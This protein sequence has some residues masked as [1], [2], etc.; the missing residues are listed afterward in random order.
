[1]PHLFLNDVCICLAFNKCLPWPFPALYFYG[2][3]RPSSSSIQQV[4]FIVWPHVHYET[5]D[6]VFS[7]RFMLV[8][9]YSRFSSADAFLQSP[10]STFFSR[11]V[12]NKVQNRLGRIYLQTSE[13]ITV[14][15]SKISLHVQSNLLSSPEWNVMSLHPDRGERTRT[16]LTRGWHSWSSVRSF[17]M[18]SRYFV[19]RIGIITLFGGDRDTFVYCLYQGAQVFTHFKTWRHSHS[20]VWIPMAMKDVFSFYSVWWVVLLIVVRDEWFSFDCLDLYVLLAIKDWDS[21]KM[22][23]FFNYCPETRFLLWNAVN[24]NQNI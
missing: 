2:M 10:A 23:F 3:C 13:R 9:F 14:Y 18:R 8:N 4:I 19:L 7:Y 1:M 5:M 21:L 22:N 11:E 17:K 15:V 24:N 20:E 16:H 6:F 12:C